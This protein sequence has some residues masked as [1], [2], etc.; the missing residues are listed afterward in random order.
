MFPCEIYANIPNV[1]FIT[2]SLSVFKIG[3]IVKSLSAN[4]RAIVAIP[5]PTSV[6]A[7]PNMALNPL[8]NAIMRTNIILLVIIFCFIFSSSSL[9]FL[10]IQEKILSQVTYSVK[11]YIEKS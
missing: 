11:I 1:K 6:F 5:T 8:M 3:C 7:S 4:T 9:I 10:V 2:R